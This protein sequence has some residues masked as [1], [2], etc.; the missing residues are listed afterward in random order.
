M[1]ANASAF[2]QPLGA[3]R[4]DQVTNMSYMFWGASAFNQPLG[5]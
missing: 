2:N 5:G 4:V 1:F 3:W